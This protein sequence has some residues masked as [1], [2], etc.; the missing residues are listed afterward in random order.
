MNVSNYRDLLDLV[1]NEG[2][3]DRLDL[4]DCAALMV[5]LD[6]RDLR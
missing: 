6:H 5:L 3:K 2:G 4:L 1:V